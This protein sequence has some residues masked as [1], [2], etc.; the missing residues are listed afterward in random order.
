MVHITRAY[1]WKM[2][3]AGRL[4]VFVER[5]MIACKSDGIEASVNSQPVEIA[6]DQT[7]T[8]VNTW[9]ETFRAAQPSDVRKIG[10]N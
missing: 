6:D 2:S 8:F 7:I 3:P 4:T 1:Q 9:Q 5:T 10:Q